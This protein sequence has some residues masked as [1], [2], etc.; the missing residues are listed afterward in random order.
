MTAERGQDGFMYEK[1]GPERLQS[2]P[3]QLPQAA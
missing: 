2:L 1:D 3:Q